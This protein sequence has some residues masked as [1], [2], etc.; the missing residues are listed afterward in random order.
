MER[1]E[2]QNA[3]AGDLAKNLMTV[4]AEMYDEIVKGYQDGTREFWVDDGNAEN[5]FRKWTKEEELAELDKAVEFYAMVVD[6]NVNRFPEEH[7][8]FMEA[9]QRLQEALGRY[10]R[11]S[12]AREAANAMD[13]LSAEENTKDIYNNLLKSVQDIK[14]GYFQY[15]DN[16]GMLVDK[17]FK[18]HI[19][20]KVT[21]R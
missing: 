13:E 19:N 1:I 9:R 10:R 8:L 3:S 18:D 6:M 5:G 20:L 4:Y 17:I 2:F 7:K 14:N 11:G 21:V 12:Q 16:L 15:K